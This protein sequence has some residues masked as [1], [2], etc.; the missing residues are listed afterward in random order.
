MNSFQAIHE[1]AIRCARQYKRAEGALI[2]AL[3]AVDNKKVYSKMG[4]SSLF[5]YARLVLHLSES[6]AYA[7]IRVAGKSIEVPQI[8]EAITAGTLCL[9]NAK[10]IAAVITPETQQLWIERASNLTQNELDKEIAK[11]NPKIS[12]PE[13]ILPKAPNRLKLE[14]G[15][16]EQIE[17]NLQRVQDLLCQQKPR[18]YA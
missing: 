4:Y 18:C 6:S 9:S 3:Q 8:K 14:L 5:E 15:I 12:I 2:S 11:E 1:N 16:S 13:R 10:R 17:K 7:F